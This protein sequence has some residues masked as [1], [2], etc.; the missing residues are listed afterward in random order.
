MEKPVVY[1]Y[2]AD[3]PFDS[4][5]LTKPTS[6]IGGRFWGAVDE[7]WPVNPAGNPLLPWI[8]IVGSELP[9]DSIS[10]FDNRHLYTF[11]ANPD[12][13]ILGPTDTTDGDFFVR[14]TRLDVKL[15]PLHFPNDFDARQ[16][17]WDASVEYEDEGPV[18]PN[19]KLGGTALDIDS[20]DPHEFAMYLG[21][22]HIYN[23]P[24]T[25]TFMFER[26]DDSTW[27]VF[28]KYA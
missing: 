4:K 13:S 14:E 24:D 22:N 18:C 11:F 21:D 15:A 9:L 16:I 7:P 8:Q 1:G 20:P 5:E 19:L 6:M 10:D 26:I 28:P 12:E 23:T 25:G 17:T 3:E 2:I 27:S